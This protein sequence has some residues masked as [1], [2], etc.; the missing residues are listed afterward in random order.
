M[1]RFYIVG[2]GLKASD[3]IVYEGIQ[4]LRDGETIRAELITE[5]TA[6]KGEQKQL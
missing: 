1:D 2:S 3:R 5:H 4:S 6:P